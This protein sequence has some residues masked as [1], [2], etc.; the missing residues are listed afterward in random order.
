MIFDD[1]LNWL[2]E[3]VGVLHGEY[4]NYSLLMQYLYSRE[5]EYLLVMDSNRASGGLSLRSL[6]ADY[7][8]VYKEDVKDG[9]C[10]VLEVLVSLAMYMNEYA[11][12]EVKD[13]FWEMIENLG[14][15]EYDDSAYD[16]GAV[17]HVIDIWLYRQF[18]EHG[19]GSPFPTDGDD[20]D[21][22]SMELWNQMH[23]YLVSKYPPGNWID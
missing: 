10:T 12:I 19:N 1:Y 14:L 6:Y 15:M 4:E 16:E 18:D 20:V 17:G 5:Y 9:P 8:G 7:A 3:Q 21:A 22:R 2:L 11:S 13:C 23:R